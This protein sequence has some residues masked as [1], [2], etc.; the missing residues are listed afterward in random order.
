MSHFVTG[1]SDD[2]QEKCHSAMLKDNMNISRLTVNSLHV[3]V[4]RDKRRSRDAKRERS[5]D[6]SFKRKA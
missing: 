2:L 1:V 6:G 3:E 4:A 5:V